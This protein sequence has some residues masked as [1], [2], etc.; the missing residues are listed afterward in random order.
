MKVCL[1]GYT[2][3]ESG[4][5]GTSL[6]ISKYIYYVAKGLKELGHDVELTVRDDFEPR[7]KWI[8]TVYSPKFT[9]LVY[10]FFIFPHL[11]NKKADVYHS[12]YVNT[13]AP[14]IWAN[15][16]P[17]VVT[18]HDV[19]PFTHNPK[20]LT[21]RDKIIVKFYKFYFNFI[22][23]ADAIVV[24][25]KTA[26]K[27]A[28]KY[29]D[30]DED[31][32]FVTIG[33]VDPKVY[34]PLKKREHEK[35]RI[36]YLG[37]LG[38]R[39]N[40]ILLV[41]TFTKMVKENNNIELHIGGGRGKE[42]EMF[43]KMKIENAYFHGFIPDKKVNE[44]LNYLDIFVCPTL[45]EGLGHDPIQAMACGL[46]IVA[47]NVTTMPEV[48]NGAGILVKPTIEDM[49]EGIKKLIESKSL[50]KKLAKK[51]YERSKEF[52]WERCVQ[53]VLKVYESV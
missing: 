24:R 33:A 29:T 47:T 26:K 50:R 42:L 53:D 45:S 20:D 25:S 18:I 3:P 1:V 48:V 15:K 51:S 44:F 27:E 11:L 17:A 43:R 6:G 46:P 35:I 19:I 14:L 41:Q 9:W 22:K 28:L 49:S 34:Y 39:K 5:V 36:G 13:G 4:K 38:G 31:K 21:T 7:E 37:G 32:L 52:T 12:D 8:K 16:R 2:V 10:P 40:V 30:I 23:N